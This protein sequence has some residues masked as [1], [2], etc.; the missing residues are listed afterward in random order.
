MKTAISIED[1]E[2]ALNEDAAKRH[3]MNRSQ[4]YTAAGRHYRQWLEADSQA[5]TTAINQALE[6]AGQPS[7]A[8]IEEF[9]D[10]SAQTVFEAVEW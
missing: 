7:V 6:H 3:A 8:Q 5:K 2:F 9:I 1:K 10:A 4:F